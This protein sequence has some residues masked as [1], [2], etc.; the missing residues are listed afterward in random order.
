MSRWGVRSAVT[1]AAVVFVTAIAASFACLSMWAGGGSD[2]LLVVAGGLP[3][4]VVVGVLLAATGWRLS[5]LRDVPLL[6][7]APLGV[8]SGAVAVSASLVVE[9][10][11]AGWADSQF[12]A[13]TAG[14]VEEAAKVAVP[15]ALW[16]VMPSMRAPRAG[17]LLATVG[18]ATFA[19]YECAHYAYFVIPNSG[20][21]TIGAAASIVMVRPFVELFHVF[22]TGFVVSVAWRAASRAGRLATAAGLGAAVV[23]MTLHA[24]NDWVNVV[25]GPV[26]RNTV[27]WS[28]IAVAFV[29]FWTQ[30]ERLR[31]TSPAT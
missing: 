30:I 18:A 26:V 23:V 6:R 29:L 17:F 21:H 11:A 2:A 9:V 27:G 16:F 1:L 25:G 14:V 28:L 10:V 15:V 31:P 3:S 13:V 7:V 5:P 22:L 24:A 12:S 20:G 8:V 4:A 19:V